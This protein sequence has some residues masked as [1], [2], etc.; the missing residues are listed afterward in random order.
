MIY[1]GAEVIVAWRS[2]DVVGTRG[3]HEGGRGLNSAFVSRSLGDSSLLD[4]RARARV[5]LVGNSVDIG[6]RR[7]HTVRRYV[8]RLVAY[9]CC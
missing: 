1:F 7:R 6:Q 8:Q 2:N 9:G 4:R 5:M 3:E